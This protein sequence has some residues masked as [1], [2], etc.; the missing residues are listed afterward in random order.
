MIIEQKSTDAACKEKL[1]WIDNT[2][3]ATKDDYVNMRT[4]FEEAVAHIVT[5]LNEPCKF[6]VSI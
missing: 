3:Q 6:S 4:M 1:A 2:P 5:K